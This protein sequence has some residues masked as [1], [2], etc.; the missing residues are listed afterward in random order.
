[1]AYSSSVF[2]INH[3]L[4]SSTLSER[5]AYFEKAMESDRGQTKESKT[6]AEN[7]PPRTPQYTPKSQRDVGNQEQLSSE[8]A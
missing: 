3:E 2:L 8:R 6:S 4:S 1:M 5:G 7:T